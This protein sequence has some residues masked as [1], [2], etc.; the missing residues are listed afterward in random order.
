M[1]HVKPVYV[2][3]IRPVCVM[4]GLD[5]SSLTCNKLISM[6]KFPLNVETLK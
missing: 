4:Y 2:D 1:Y 6:L 3:H 5:V